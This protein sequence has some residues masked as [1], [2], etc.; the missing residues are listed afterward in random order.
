MKISKLFLSLLISGSSLGTAA[1]QTHSVPARDAGLDSSWSEPARPSRHIGDGA[2]VPAAP[3]YYSPANSGGT[4]GS[5][6]APTSGRT[7]HLGDTA[8]LGDALAV[9]PAA[10]AYSPAR[11]AAYNTLQEPAVANHDY[12]PR[13]YACGPA[14]CDYGPS[15]WFTSETLLW[16]GQASN[17]PPLLATAATGIVPAV[18]QPAD[19]LV[20]GTN[21]IS[22]GLLPGYRFSG[23]FY[24]GPEQKL[25]LSGRVFGLIRNSQSTTAASDGTTS[26][27]LPYFDVNAGNEST[28]LLAFPTAPFDY[29]GGATVTTDLELIAAEPSLRFLIGRSHDHKVELLGGYTFLRMNDSLTVNSQVTS[30]AIGNLVPQGTVETLTDS[31]RTSNTFHG[32]HLGLETSILRRRLSLSTLAKVSLGN[33]SQRSII[34]GSTEEVQPAPAVPATY[35]GGLY[36]QQSNIGTITRDQFGFIPELGLKGGFLL[37]EN[38]QLT[39]GYTF[40][41]LSNVA[42]AGEQIDRNIDITQRLGGAPGTSPA[43]QLRDGSMWLQGLDLGVN[44]TF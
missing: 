31:F 6:V 42:R 19:I 20:G 11:F 39:A 32:G 29:S 14:A 36:A 16:F 2:V 17:A 37:R 27:G 30:D 12:A 4:V 38:L 25:G 13:S 35:V 26:I 43:A 21:G 9:A 7:A 3:N 8:S 24:F 10:T 22:S 41:Y 28:F 44:W 5:E 18:G 33:F 23:G 34:S 15:A 1:A 40:L